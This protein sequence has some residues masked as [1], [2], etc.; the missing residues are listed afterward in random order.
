[1]T[2]EFE[3]KKKWHFTLCFTASQEWEFGKIPESE[4]I[5]AGPAANCESLWSGTAV[6]ERGLEKRVAHVS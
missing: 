6:G 3:R 1:M 2:M 4:I 5:Q